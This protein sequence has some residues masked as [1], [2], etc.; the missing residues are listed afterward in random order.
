[1]EGGGTPSYDEQV[2]N[3]RLRIKSFRNLLLR[4]VV[5]V[6]GVCVVDSTK[7]HGR[8]VLGV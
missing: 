2:G 7:G 3:G 6:T 1:M 8:A 5:G 4:D